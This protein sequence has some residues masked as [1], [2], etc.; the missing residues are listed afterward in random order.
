MSGLTAWIMSITGAVCLGA[1]ADVLMAEGSTKKYVKGIVALIVFAAILAPIPAILKGNFDFGFGVTNEV[2]DDAFVTEVAETRYRNAEAALETALA[3]R[4]YEG[5]VV[6]VYLNYGS[7]MPEVSAVVVDVTLCVINRDKENINIR[8]D[9]AEY[10]AGAL[11][12]EPALV[13]VVS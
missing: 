1:L 6:R 3:A 9:I 12:V 4:G 13:T 10:V 2:A 11:G 5:S 7:D 8:E